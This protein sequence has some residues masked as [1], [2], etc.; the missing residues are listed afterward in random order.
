MLSNISFSLTDIN[1]DGQSDL[2]ISLTFKKSI[3]IG[4]KWFEVW[5]QQEKV[6]ELDYAADIGPKLIRQVKWPS[7]FSLSIC[8]SVHSSNYTNMHDI[9]YVDIFICTLNISLL[10]V[11]GSN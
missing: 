2:L 10:L 9:N 1:E 7:K 5:A 8:Q 6:S 4:E 11:A 3:I